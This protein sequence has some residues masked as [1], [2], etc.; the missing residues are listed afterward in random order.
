MTSARLL[1]GIRILDLS[2]LIAG[3]SATSMLAEQGADVI[4]LESPS[5]DPSRN[6]GVARRH[7]FSSPFAAYNK[8]KRSVSINLQS[9]DGRQIC[10]QLI[11][12]A[13]VLI[14]AFRPGVMDRLGLGLE[15]VRELNPGIVYVSF[16]GFG[17]DGPMAHRPGVDLLIQGESGIM[18][19]TGE[20][21]GDPLKIGFTAVDAAAGF[22]LSGAI[23]SGLLKKART[24]QGSRMEMSLMDVALYMQAGPITEYL[25][26]NT[27]PQRTGNKAPLGSPAEVF[28]TKDGTLIVSAYF[29]NQWGDLCR[30]LGLQSLFD[31]PRFRDNESRIANRAKLHDLLQ[32]CFIKKASAEWKA[33]F[34]PTRIIFGDV[35]DYEQVAASEQVKHSQALI[36]LD[37][38]EGTVPSVAAPLKTDSP[39]PERLPL[40]RLGEHTAEVLAE[41][42]YTQDQV[43]ALKEKGVVS[44]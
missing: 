5:G 28:K 15:Q 9:E 17:E 7:G 26:S 30:I 2:Q 19:I 16:S 34:E 44:Y 4:K 40:P 14:E 8:G 21:D 1:D 25:M 42:G 31:D 20:E 43:T 3:P 41:L 10:R 27:V 11:A 23:L 32:A 22:A 36:N 33:L 12:S 24:G 6:M 37:V 29:V 38:A 39:R 35:L 13:D 18:S